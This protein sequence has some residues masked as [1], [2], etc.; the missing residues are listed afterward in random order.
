MIKL[1]TKERF[2]DLLYYFIGVD[3]TGFSETSLLNQAFMELI[4]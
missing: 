2:G 4:I 1:H 3:R